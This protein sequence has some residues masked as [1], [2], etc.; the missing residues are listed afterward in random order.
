MESKSEPPKSVGSLKRKTEATKFSL[1][2]FCQK[3]KAEP[4]RTGTVAAKQKVQTC[5]TK[6]WK[7]RDKRNIDI[8]DRLHRTDN[9]DW[10]LDL[11]AIIW[12]KKCYSSF[13][14]ITNIHFVENRGNISTATDCDLEIDGSSSTES[15][16]T[17]NTS[18]P[19]DWKKCMFCQKKREGKIAFCSNSGKI[20]QNT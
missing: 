14:S 18:T 4:L 2:V 20:F 16:S 12:H 17:R 15:A 5:I 3:K 8:L 11:Y 13:T 9:D 1:C 6:R 19:I 10:N 7:N